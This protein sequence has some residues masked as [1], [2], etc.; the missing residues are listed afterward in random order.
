V[1]QASGLLPNAPTF[2]GTDS[3]LYFGWYVGT[4]RDLAHAIGAVPRLGRFVS[5]FGAQS[6]P[7]DADFCEPDRWPHLDWETLGERH[8]L[9]KLWFD[10][11]VAPH[12]YATFDEWA[13]ATQQYQ[14]ELVR[15]QAEY[16]RRI[17]YRPNG[18]FAQF[19]FADANPAVSWSVLDHE[20]RPK[21]AYEALSL[22]CAPVIVTADEPP[23]TVGVGQALTLDVHAVSDVRSTI[24][25]AVTKVTATWPN[26]EHRWGWRGKLHADAATR[27]GSIRFIV[28]ETRGTLQFSLE[29]EAGEHRATNIY[30]TEVS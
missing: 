11:Y 29:L 14:A 1:I 4:R 30:T 13:E 10:R 27:V 25:E 18:G 12:E 26:G 21:L 5:E 28:P 7:T 23:L 22:A 19:C 24:A 2:D 20:L 16:L 9:Q 15:R 3:H 17:K 6:V 8:S